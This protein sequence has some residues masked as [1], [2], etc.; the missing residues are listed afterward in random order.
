MKSF[1]TFWQLK[2][3]MQIKSLTCRQKSTFKRMQLLLEPEEL[4][5]VEN[6]LNQ[7]KS[8]NEKNTKFGSMLNQNTNL[9]FQSGATMFSLNNEY[10]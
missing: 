2:M 9:I 5:K 10:S 3:S 4:M 8:E 7:N 1:E 6:E